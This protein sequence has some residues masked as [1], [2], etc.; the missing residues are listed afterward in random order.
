MKTKRLISLVLTT[1]MMFTMGITVFAAKSTTATV[2]VTLTVSN[3]YRAVNVTVPASFPV[4]VINGVVVTANNA[5]IT[6]NAKSGAVKI[7]AIINC[8]WAVVTGVILYI[9]AEPAL[10]I[11]CEEQ[12]VLEQGVYMLR[13]TVPFY[14]LLGLNQVFAGAINGSGDTLATMTITFST[15]CVMRVLILKI[16]GLF[17]YTFDV[18]FAAYIVTWF[19]CAGLMGAYYF[20]GRWKRKIVR[21]ET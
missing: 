4:E 14:F 10:A 3:E 6:N 15:M 17:V 13:V 12:E 21:H 19:A 11:F 20:S 9:L 8:S 2:P 18:V 1:A 16:M 5:K 7:T